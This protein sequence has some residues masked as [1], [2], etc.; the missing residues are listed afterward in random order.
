MKEKTILNITWKF[1]M[2]VI[3]F[4]LSVHNTHFPFFNV[5]GMYVS[6]IY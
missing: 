4:N 3:Q 6:D 2:K 1:S 5:I